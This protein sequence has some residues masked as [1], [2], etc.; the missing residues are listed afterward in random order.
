MF[1]DFRA[2]VLHANFVFQVELQFDDLDNQFCPYFALSA[3]VGARYCFLDD[4]FN[5]GSSSFH[6]FRSK[7]VVGHQCEVDRVVPL[8]SCQ[9]EVFRCCVLLQVV[10]YRV[11]EY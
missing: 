4:S 9:L 11:A 1:L 7:A 3:L 6:S 8:D 5:G 2:Q 10:V